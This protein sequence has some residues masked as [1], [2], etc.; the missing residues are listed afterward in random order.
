MGMNRLIQS[1]DQGKIKILFCNNAK[2]RTQ[3]PHCMRLEKIKKSAQNPRKL[4]VSQT[5][6]DLIQNHECEL[7]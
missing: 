7:I 4:R 2:Y 1:G 5:F 6:L 3:K